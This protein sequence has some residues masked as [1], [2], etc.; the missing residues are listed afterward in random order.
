M[1][2]K[3][4][5]ANAESGDDVDVVLEAATRTDVEKIAHEKGI[6]V[7]SIAPAPVHA[8]AEAIAMVEDEPP[9][10]GKE[11]VPHAHG[12]ITVNANSP[13]EEAHSGEGHIEQEKHAEA[14]MEYHIM[15]NQSLYL[16]ET[17]VNRHIVQGWEPQGGVS[18]ASANNA[19]QYFQALVRKKK[20]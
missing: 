9:V 20:A 2:F 3:I 12:M 10:N 11:A 13:S 17:A 14:A 5:G 16:L 4:T 7:S 6:M 18:I 8:E 15:M 19:L 1:R